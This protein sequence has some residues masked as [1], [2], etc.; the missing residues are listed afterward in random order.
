MIGSKRFGRSFGRTGRRPGF[1]QGGRFHRQGVLLCLLPGNE[2]QELLVGHFAN[3]EL[4]R[5]ALRAGK[6]GLFGRI[7]TLE[8]ANRLQGFHRLG[9]D[10]RSVV[11]V[12]LR[13]MEASSE[14]A[15]SRSEPGVLT[16]RAD[17]VFRLTR[18]RRG[19]PPGGCPGE[20]R[21]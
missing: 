8:F 11:L 4:D 9:N 1:G 7:E 14:L 12:R 18:C 16:G 20:D 6:L 2:G 21:N 3:R 10:C 19:G 15:A 13:V 5:A 17:S